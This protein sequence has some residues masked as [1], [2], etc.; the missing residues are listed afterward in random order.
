MPIKCPFYHGS[1]YKLHTAV[2]YIQ[3]IFQLMFDCLE[4]SHESMSLWGLLGIGR[5]WSSYICI[6]TEGE[7]SDD[8]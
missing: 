3:H 5:Y 8:M 6:F 7:C 2:N 1:A 4:I